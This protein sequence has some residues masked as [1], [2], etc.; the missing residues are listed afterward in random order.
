M[1]DVAGAIPPLAVFDRQAPEVHAERIAH[2][3]RS[4]QTA[5]AGGAV[6]G[7]QQLLFDD[8]LNR[9]HV[10]ILFNNILHSQSGDAQGASPENCAGGDVDSTCDSVASVRRRRRRLVCQGEQQKVIEYLR[11]ENRV[12][13]AQLRNYGLRP[14]DD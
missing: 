11:E 14:T 9:L 6:G 2:E 8:D 12:L 5:A 4:I 13:Q 1:A 3:R 7:L 10:W